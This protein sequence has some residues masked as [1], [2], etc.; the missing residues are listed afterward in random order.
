MSKLPGFSLN[1]Y[2]KDTSGYIV[3]T[4]NISDWVERQSRDEKKHIDTK[5][6]VGLLLVVE[7]VSTKKHTSWQRMWLTCF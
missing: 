1:S 4:Y 2:A 6:V 7:V 5:K 3:G